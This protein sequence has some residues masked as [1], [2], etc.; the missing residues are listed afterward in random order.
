MGRGI[1][2]RGHGQGSSGTSIGRSSG[3]MTRPARDR[4][5]ATH[6]EHAL[7]LRR[8][9]AS[10]RTSEA[11]ARYSAAEPPR[12]P[13]WERAR[14]IHGQEPLVVEVSVQQR[15]APAAAP[16]PAGAGACRAR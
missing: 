2:G 11:T 9:A 10:V 3:K 15:R 12:T 4:R 13:C 5:T 8:F 14:H 1:A 16:R 6:D 7:H